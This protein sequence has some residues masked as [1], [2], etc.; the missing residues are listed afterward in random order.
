MAGDYIIVAIFIVV[1]AI[2]IIIT[3][4]AFII[5]IVIVILKSSYSE[6]CLLQAP[7]CRVKVDYLSFQSY[8]CHFAVSL[9]ALK[10]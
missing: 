9:L 2:I 1:V 6:A 8:T 7:I 10:V 4:I 5:V 3:T